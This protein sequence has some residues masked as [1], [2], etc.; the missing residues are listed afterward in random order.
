MLKPF[1]I[2]LLIAVA[3]SPGCQKQASSSG[4]KDQEDTPITL[5]I[6]GGA[7]AIKRAAL[8]NAQK[9]LYKQHLKAALNQGYATLENGGKAAKAVE[10][11]LRALETDSLFNAGRGSV[12]DAN[13]NVRMDAALMRGVDKQAGA[14]ASVGQ[15]QHPISG[16]RAVLDSSEHVMLVAQGGRQFALAHGVEPADSAYLVTH[17]RA[18]SFHKRTKAK[19]KHEGAAIQKWGTVGA[20]AL[21]QQG[22]LAAGTS[23][24]GL[25]NK[26]PG[27]V[28]DSPT[29]G[30]GTYA[31]N[32]TCAVSATGQGEFFMRH[33]IAYDVAAR[34]TYQ[35]QKLQTAAQNLIHTDLTKVGGKGGLIAL[36]SA[37]NI[38]MPFNTSGMFRA[39]KKQG[40]KARAR[41][42]PDK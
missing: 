27:R 40:S 2:S 37:G 25:S 14:I 7:G 35:D 42:F 1:I 32:A 31:D 24:G 23:T 18:K 10:Q 33:L 22:H 34:M 9:Q 16:A 13:G 19:G 4:E 3:L 30:A 17:S 11:A 26:A 29:I 39:V 36:D 28:G 15:I 8:S 5:V 20:V 38:A 12:L 41:I 21:D 6:H